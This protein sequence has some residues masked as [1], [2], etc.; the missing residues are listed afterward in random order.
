MTVLQQISVIIPVYNH[1]QH[2]FDSLQSLRAQTYKN[3]EVIVVDDGSDTPLNQKESMA[4]VHFPIQ[5]VRQE[6]GGAPVARNHGFQ[7]SKGEF[8]IFW[9]ADVIAEPVMLQKMYDVLV[10]HPE[11]SFSYSNF[12]FGRKKMPACPFDRTTLK[13]NN[14]ITTTS[15]IRR[16]AFPGWDETLKRFQD[17]DLWLTMAEQGKNGVWIPEYLFRVMPH[18]GGMSSWLPSFAYQAPW[19]YLPGISTKVRHYE[20]ARRVVL[21]KHHL[22]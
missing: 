18:H 9:D 1:T 12:Y 8:V 3:F 11:T 14:Y 22:S 19:K 15:L 5:W 21:G 13:K 4:D 16:G 20:T 7:V 6:H 10:Q 17:W 2:L